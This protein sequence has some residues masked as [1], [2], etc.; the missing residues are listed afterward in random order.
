M[1]YSFVYV[2]DTTDNPYCMYIT[3]TAKN[4]MK[5]EISGYRLI[6]PNTK[7]TDVN[8]NTIQYEYA[9]LPQSALCR[10]PLKTLTSSASIVLRYFC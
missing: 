9:L 7:N 2:N 8:T 4:S 5:D 10:S 6:Q 3:T 1:V